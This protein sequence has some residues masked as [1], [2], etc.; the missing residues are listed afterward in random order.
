MKNKNLLKNTV[1]TAL[2]A[3]LV[4]VATM[5][6]HI[7]IPAPGAMGYINF[8]DCVVLTSGL[9]LGPLYGGLASGIG[10]C[11]ADATYGH[12]IYVPGTFVVKALMAAT[13][14][15]I[16]KCIS[17]NKKD[18]KT[19]PLIISSIAGECVM[20]FGYFL[21]ESA[22]PGIG[23][24]GAVLGVTANISQALAGAFLTFLIIKLMKKAKIT[25][26]L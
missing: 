5:V 24:P 12:M 20:V 8:G 13:S 1:Y 9:L 17:K 11:L 14:S 26:M 19:L 15:L 2:F 10:S 6:I 7:H 22:L 21:Y 4:Y 16:Y 25:D 3:A 18:Y 23:V